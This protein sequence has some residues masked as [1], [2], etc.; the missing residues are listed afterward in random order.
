[1]SY[2]VMRRE[3]WSNI[4]EYGQGGR[5]GDDELMI[6]RAAC[7]SLPATCQPPTSPP[8]RNPP[9]SQISNTVALP[10]CH[11]SPILLPSLRLLQQHRNFLPSRPSPSLL[12]RRPAPRHSSFGSA[13]PPQSSSP[14]HPSYS[15]G[16]FPPTPALWSSRSRAAVWSSQ[17]AHS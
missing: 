13:A 14:R 1:M 3:R 6:C 11:L 12:I 16:R 4:S 17:L 7:H 9:T 10:C 2:Q 8:C 5:M 15:S